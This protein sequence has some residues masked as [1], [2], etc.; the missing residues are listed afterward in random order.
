MYPL[1]IQRIKYFS[2]CSE[3]MFYDLKSKSSNTLKTE[4]NYSVDFF[5]ASEVKKHAKYLFAL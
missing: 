5:T 4:T 3:I 2:Y 1:K